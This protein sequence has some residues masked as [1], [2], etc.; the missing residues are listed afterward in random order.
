MLKRRVMA[1]FLVVVALAVGYF[2]YNSEKPDSKFNF[3][4]GLDLNGGSHLVYKADTTK[5]SSG[6]INEAMS[7][8]R[9]TIERRV[10]MFGVS[11]P[12][13]QVEDGVRVVVVD[14]EEEWFLLHLSE[15]GIELYE[16]IPTDVGIAID[17][18]GKMLVREETR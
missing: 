11:E 18:D 7:A 8:L 13:V 5:I 16:D 17:A 4:L 9:D 14:G 1:I 2:V 12:I 3:K 10:N 15:K 6:D